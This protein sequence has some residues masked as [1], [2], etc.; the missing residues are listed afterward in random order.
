MPDGVP[1]VTTI[2]LDLRVLA[3]AAGLS[4]IT[5]ALFGIVPAL[6]MS[7]PDLTTSLKEGVQS[8]G[9]VRQRLRSVLVV[10]EVA[11]AVVLLVG[12]ALFI[13]SFIRLLAVDPGFNP[14]GVLTMQLYASAQPGQRRP[15]WTPAF[16]QIIERLGHT[17]GVISAAAA[18]PGIP[19]T[20]NMTI[21]AL[22]VPGSSNEGDLGVSIKAVTPDYHRAMRIPLRAGR[23]FDATDRRGAAGVVIITESV[24]RS[25]FPNQDPIQR[26]VILSN[27]PLTVVGVVADVRQWTLEGN[28]RPEVYIAMAQGETSSGYLVIGTSVDPYD[29]LPAVK[30]IATSVLPGVPLR[31]VTSMQQA[32]DRQMAQRR[33]NML[34]LG[35]F[36]LLGLVIS[37]VGV[38]GVMAYIVSQ[39]TR[40]IGVRMALGATRSKV[41]GMV[42]ANACAL[43]FAGLAV[44]GI[45]AWYLGA[46]AQAFLFGIEPHDA[47]AFLAAVVALSAAAITASAIPARRAAGVDPTVALRGE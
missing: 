47:R 44:G 5:G 4:V 38:Y 7:K 35:L 23:L 11:L 20:R 43:V 27:Q 46:T 3:A 19:F 22:R 41:V 12:A 29:V 25:A 2:A 45:G 6:Q 10:A 31:Y 14:E 40:E 1:R 18:S 13:G 26:T 9:R 30:T 33:L 28:S 24:A 42:L 37:A 21:D 8:A 36:G 32:M 15:D 34:M 17:P 39:R 16:A